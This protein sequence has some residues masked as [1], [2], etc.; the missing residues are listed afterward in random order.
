MKTLKRNRL[1]QTG[2]TL[3]EYKG[4]EGTITGIT[5]IE[6]FVTV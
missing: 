3:V 1:L 6:G 2:M 4:N 5:Y